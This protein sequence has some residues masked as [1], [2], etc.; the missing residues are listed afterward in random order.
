M[1]VETMTHPRRDGVIH[2][3]PRQLDDE[4]TLGGERDARSANADGSGCWR[5][6]N[7]RASLPLTP[8]LK[9]SLRVEDI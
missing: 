4:P 3:T 5:A 7:G 1:R 2:L 8:L 6:I 9:E